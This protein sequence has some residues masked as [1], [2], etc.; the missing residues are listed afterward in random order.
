MDH[1]MFHHLFHH[2]VV[3]IINM[4]PLSQNSIAMSI[5]I[6]MIRGINFSVNLGAFIMVSAHSGAFI[7]ERPN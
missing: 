5:P 6:D 7:K 3:F 1:T 4:Y 2:Y